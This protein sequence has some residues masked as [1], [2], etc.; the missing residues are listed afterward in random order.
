MGLYIYIP[1]AGVPLCLGN[2]PSCNEIREKY[3]APADAVL[4]PRSREGRTPMT[5]SNFPLACTIVAAL[6]VL[7]LIGLLL[8]KIYENR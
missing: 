5:T 3:F 6:A 1:R 8:F 2:L 4:C 7:T